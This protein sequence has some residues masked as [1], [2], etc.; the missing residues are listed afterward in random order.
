[1]SDGLIEDAGNSEVGHFP[2]CD[3]L[4]QYHY[5]VLL[6]SISD[7]LKFFTD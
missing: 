5:G 3:T 1:M 7:G 4:Y 6:F 2:G